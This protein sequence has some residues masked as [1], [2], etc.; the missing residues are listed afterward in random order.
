MKAMRKSMAERIVATLG[1]DPELLAQM[2]E[3]GVLRREWVEEP[4]SGPISDATPL[5]VLERTLAGMVERR[6][7]M[8]AS[9][10]LSA[11]E[12]LS[13][14][15]DGEAEPSVSCLT[16]AFTDLEDFTRFTAKAGDAA[17]ARLLGQHYQTAGP[18]VR[19]RGGKVVKRL[20]DGLMMTFPEP[21][22]AVLAAVELCE[23]APKPLKVRAGLHVGE[24]IVGHSDVLGHVVNIAARVTE[25]AAGGEVLI[26]HDLRDMLLLDELPQIKVGRARKRRLKGVGERIEVTPVA[27]A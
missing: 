16:V 23:H 24:V 25:T 4:G 22:A 27:R 7:S 6:P 19:S 26:S 9:L 11:I 1:K 12:V 21:T 2:T 8:L 5:E 14:S 15:G 20:G 17:A 18:I 10:G 3:T 13:A